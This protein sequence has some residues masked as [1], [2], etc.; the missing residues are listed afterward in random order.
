MRLWAEEN[1]SG[2]VEL[3]FTMPLTL[4][5]AVT[6]KF[7]SAWFVVGLS[8]LLTFP[9]AVTVIYL[10]SPDIGLMLSGYLASILI[11]GAFLAIGSFTSAATK[12]QVISFIISLVLC[13]LLILAGHPAITNYFT[14][15]APEWFVSMLSN[16]S[17]MPHY[18]T[19]KRG[20]IDIKDI[21]YFVSVIVFFLCAT[22]VV[23]NT[24]KN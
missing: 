24:R 13:L 18:E 4:S 12:S 1:R 9:L 14:S 23:L 2:T 7:L 16:L 19:L 17:V 15:W 21:S 20:L 3:L 8:L 6:A 22:T 11:S 10:G 5:E